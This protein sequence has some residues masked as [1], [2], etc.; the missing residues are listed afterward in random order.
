MVNKAKGKNEMLETIVD[1]LGIV[2]TIISIVVTGIGI[3]FIQYFF[4]FLQ[5]SCA[6]GK[7]YHCDIDS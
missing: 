4:C 3:V 1:V 2:V 6:S 7:R 5:D